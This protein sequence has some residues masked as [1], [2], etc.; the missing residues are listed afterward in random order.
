MI[1]TEGE[2]LTA[3][4]G[5]EKAQLE[6]LRGQLEEEVIQAKWKVSRK[7]ERCKM[8][9][10]HSEAQ[11]L[12]TYVTVNHTSCVLDSN[13]DLDLKRKRKKSIFSCHY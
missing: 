6:R 10:R 2:I 9:L 4:E 1:T 7:R 8:E 3:I 11:K 5:Y 13:S 12:S